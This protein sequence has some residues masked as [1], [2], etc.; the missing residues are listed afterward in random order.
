MFG[1]ELDSS[2]NLTTI[3]SQENE[4]KGCLEVEE[5]EKE[6]EEQTDEEVP[7]VLAAAAVVLSVPVVVGGAWS[8]CSHQASQVSRCKSVLVSSQFSTQG[9]FIC[10]ITERRCWHRG[11]VTHYCQI[12]EEQRREWRGVERSEGWRAARAGS[13]RQRATAA[14]SGQKGGQ[15]NYPTLI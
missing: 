3:I 14:A 15:S 11:H 4:W 7:V 12:Y 1:L 13:E 5:I 8:G 10:L 2:F 6:Q 9:E